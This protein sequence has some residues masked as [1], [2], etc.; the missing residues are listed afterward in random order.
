MNKEPCPFPKS[1]TYHNPKYEEFIRSHPC[2]LCGKESVCHHEQGLGIGLVGGGMGKK[3]SSLAGVPLCL[4]C[5]TLRHDQGYLTFWHRVAG[6]AGDRNIGGAYGRIIADGV[7][8]REIIK[9]QME[10]IERM[11]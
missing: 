7:A 5:H 6:F 10:W 11:L 9:L 1:K 2:I 3:C 4:Q 8:M